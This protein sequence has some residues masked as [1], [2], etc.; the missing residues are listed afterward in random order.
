MIPFSTTVVGSSSTPDLLQ[1]LR[2]LDDELG[3]VDVVLGEVAVAQVD[4]ALEV[5]VVGRHVVGADQR[6]RCS[7]PG[8]RTVATT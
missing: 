4:A 2:N 1:P 7:I 5:G 6:R 3:V 8:R